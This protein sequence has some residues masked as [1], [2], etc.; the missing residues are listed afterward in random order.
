MGAPWLW[1]GVFAAS[2]GLLIAGIV[3]ARAVDQARRDCLRR[4]YL[5]RFPRDLTTDSTL[6]FLATLTGLATPRQGWF[7]RDAVV[8]AVVGTSR[9]IEH[10]LWLP[11]G[12]ASYYLAQLRAAVPS[13]AVTEVEPGDKRARLP[14]FTAGREL[15]LTD[16]TRALMTADP[17]AVSRTIMSACTGLRS[18]EAVIWAWTVAGGQPLASDS[19]DA[20]LGTWLGSILGAGLTGT[21]AEIAPAKLRKSTHGLTRCVLRIGAKASD[22]KRERALLARLWRAA[23][24]VSAPGV[25]LLPRR[26]PLVL[27][28]WRLARLATPLVTFPTLLTPPELLA[29]VGWPLGSPAVPG[30]VV[31]ASPQLAPTPS[32]P[33]RGRVLGHATTGQGRPVAQSLRGA[34][35]HTLIVAPTGAGKTW[36]AAHMALDDIRAGRGVLVLDPKGGLIRAIADRLPEE[37]I[38]RTVL[39]DPSD[40]EQPVP[41]PLLSHERDAIPE[42]AADTLIGLLRH[43]YTDLGPRSTDILASSLYALAKTGDATVMDLL[44]L[45]SDTRYRASVRSRVNGDPALSSFFAW[46]EAL[47]PA[48]RSFVLAAPMNKLRPLV[49]RPL[50]RNLLAAP[51]QTFSIPE[52]LASGQVVLVSLPEGI[53]G[54]EVTTL[55]GQVVLSRLWT[56]VQGRGKRRDP[57]L[58]TIDEA[59]R[60]LDQPTDIG[61]ALARSREYGVGI[62]LVTQSL[63]QLPSGLREVALNSAR[64]KVAFQS[65]AADA[66]R[67]A[68]EFGPTV[69]ADMLT[70]LARYEAIAQVSIGAATSDPFTFRSPG[71]DK[72]ERG[73]LAAVR[74]ASR[75]RYGIPREEI[76]ASFSVP[77]HPE[78]GGIGPIGRRRDT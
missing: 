9:A 48:E 10:R 29:L 28:T 8:M 47:S 67:L 12:S 14:R 73:R 61:D 6:A 34:L 75:A 42:L 23:G 51:R 27:S 7:G 43:R 50:V 5:V 77:D 38:S 37:A 26:L 78:D 66:R 58:V 71:L 3:S 59:P 1:L 74:A 60:F 40:T 33:R 21:T 11:R 45:W 25:R 46:F 13:V 56:A 4:Q 53:L 24:S 35:E 17:L 57:F 55:L 68:A 49:A 20:G 32:V 31:G 70:G 54:A 52:A 76:E 36:L 65:S 16:Q 15:R 2:G 22:R 39:I 64:T 44:R 19:G 18:G 63:A 69:T 62:T 72:P 41:L 30:L